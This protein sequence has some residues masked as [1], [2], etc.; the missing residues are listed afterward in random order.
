MGTM[1]P[2]QGHEDT[3]TWLV[4]WRQHAER[5]GTASR[6][7]A[8]LP[9]VLRWLPPPMAL[10]AHPLPVPLH[11]HTP[12]TRLQRSRSS[13]LPHGSCHSIPHTTASP[14][15]WNLCRSRDC[16][17]IYTEP[18]VGRASSPPTAPCGNHDC[19]PTSRDSLETQRDTGPGHTQQLS[20]RPC[21]SSLHRTGHHQPAQLPSTP[22]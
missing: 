19:R 13:V 16:G 5:G 21:A 18:P 2:P 7:L 22:R 11:L 6:G 8:T 17:N 12:P 14:S 3:R 1:E 10:E 20:S 9:D 4:A 15:A